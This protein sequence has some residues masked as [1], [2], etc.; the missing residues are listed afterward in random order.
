M[1]LFTGAHHLSLCSSLTTWQMSNDDRYPL[2][3]LVLSVPSPV[4]HFSPLFLTF[5]TRLSLET[6]K[7]LIKVCHCTQMSVA[8]VGE[9]WWR[10]W[11]HIIQEIPKSLSK[12]F[13]NLYKSP[14]SSYRLVVCVYPTLPHVWMRGAGGGFK[15]TPCVTASPAHRRGVRNTFEATPQGNSWRG[16]ITAFPTANPRC[17]SVG[18]LAWV[19]YVF[20]V[21]WVFTHQRGIPA[22]GTTC[23]V[24][25]VGT[26]QS[27][28]SP[29]PRSKSFH[30]ERQPGWT[31]TWFAFDRSMLTVPFTF[32]S[33]ERPL[34]MML[35]KSAFLILSVITLPSPFISFSLNQIL[36]SFL[37][38][39]HLQNHFLL[40]FMT[41]VSLSSN[42]STF[43]FCHWAVKQC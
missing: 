11:Q 39:A 38:L 22:R 25:P 20:G 14:L 33:R 37:K 35:S 4:A 1:K 24:A 2:S 12:R 10:R 21:S 36:P 3:L 28:L 43:W 19:R 27:L 16:G 18:V 41:L 8:M 7:S 26:R 23:A 29:H 40:S 31:R 42:Q 32:W 6:V 34:K 5:Q 15:G 17:T 9:G 30:Q 13:P